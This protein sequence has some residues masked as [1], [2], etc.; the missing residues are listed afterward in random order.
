MSFDIGSTDVFS[1]HVTWVLG[2]CNFLEKDL[3]TA[4]VMLN[5]QQCCVQAADLADARAPANAKWLP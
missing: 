2:A 5:P 4:Y 1:E 3:A